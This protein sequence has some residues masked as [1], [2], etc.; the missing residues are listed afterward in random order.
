[1]WSKHAR[2]TL[3]GGRRMCECVS[4]YA[5]ICVCVYVCVNLSVCMSVCV[6]VCMRVCACV[7]TY[8]EIR[9]YTYMYAMLCDK[10]MV[11]HEVAIMTCAPKR[12]A[13]AL[14]LP[15]ISMMAS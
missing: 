6:Y 12:T 14:Q 11:F 13:I 10:G 4:V 1:M 15:V 2:S 8:I 3:K 9:I 5:C 7:H